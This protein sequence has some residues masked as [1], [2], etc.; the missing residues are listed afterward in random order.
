MH[1]PRAVGRPARYA[2]ESPWR[3]GAAK[4]LHLENHFELFGLAPRYAL[5]EAALDRA[6][7]DIQA[8]VHPDRYAGA[9]DAERRVSMQR[10][11]QVNEA[12]RVLRDPLERAAYLLALRGIDPKFESDTGMPPEFLMRQ[13][14]FREAL[15]EAS[16]AADEAALE[17][18]HARL[19]VETGAVR[20]SLATLIDG[21]SE[22]G[23]AVR[24]VRELMFLQ[25]L[26]GDVERAFEALEA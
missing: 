5:D 11:T 26:A 16:K 20:E 23:A 17:R 13:M 10:T 3:I 1:D 14:D 12:Y 4:A 9:G 2:G 6:W 7:R 15:D 8:Q 21:G 18:L 25:K 22:P 19:G 24:A